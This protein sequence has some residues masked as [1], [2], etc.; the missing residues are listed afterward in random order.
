MRGVDIVDGWEIRPR[1]DGSFGV[2]D[3]HGLV[4]GPYGHKVDALRA[5]LRLPKPRPGLWRG[6]ARPRIRVTLTMREPRSS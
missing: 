3:D 5:A 2:Y 1:A 6:L 4:E